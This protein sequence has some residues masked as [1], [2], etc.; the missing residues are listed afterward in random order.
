[1]ERYNAK[2]VEEKW[3]KFWEKEKIY[4]FDPK[5]KKKIYSIDTPPPTISG[6][7]HLGTAFSY[8]QQDFIVRFRRMNGFNIFYPFGTDDNG[9]ATIRLIEKEKKVKAFDLGREKFIKLV[10]ETLKKELRPK[11]IADWK[12]LGMS[13]EWNIYYTTIDD[14]CRKISQKS[15]IE[16]YKKG[17][18]Y[19]KRTP[20]M[21]C[22]EC[23]TSIAQVEMKD[24]ETKS[25][26]VYIKLNT[27]L[28][29]PITIATT[30]P[31]LMPACVAVHVNPKDKRYKKF[32][33]KKAKLPLFDRE[34]NIYA[35][36]DVDMDFGSGAVYHC[37][38]GDMD[39]VEW[40]K[41]MNLD[42]IEI[43]NKDGTF[44]EKAGK[45]K[46]MKS[47]QVREKIIGDLKKLKVIEKIEPIEHVINVHE[48]CDTPI[49]IL[50]TEQW[51][52]KY[53]DLKKQMLNWGKKLNWYPKYMKVRYDNWVKGLKWDWNISRQKFYGIP[54]PVWYCKKCNEIILADE[55]QLPVDPL[56]D[57][58]KKKCKCG[59]DE[60]EG[61]KDVLDTWA[62]SSLTPQIAI[63]LMPKEIQ[64]KLFPMSLRPQAHDIISFWLFKT[65]VKN[66]LHYHKNPFKDVM[67][68]GFVLDPEGKKMSKSKGNVIAP[69]DIIDTYGADALRFWAAGSKLG[70]DLS[71]QEKDL[72][73]GKK[74]ITKLLNASRFVF[75]NLK[76]YKGQKPKKFE[77]LDRL[78]L[79]MLD[80]H[81]MLI[82]KNFKEYNYSM[83]KSRIEKLFWSH[84]CD[85][86][87][88]IIK[89]RIY[90]GK[91]DK[92]ISAQ[93]TLYHSL[94]IILKLVAPIMPF[95]AEEIYQNYFKE[96]E[97][98]KSIHISKW[99]EYKKAPKVNDF[100]FLC[101]LL[102]MV[103]KEKTKKQKSMNAECII[104]LTKKDSKEV[105]KFLEDFKSASGAYVVEVGKDF[106]VEFPKAGTKHKP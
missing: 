94:L 37:T 81:V 103:R 80:Y 74:F 75:M 8:S 102:S 59:N 62:T 9:L 96:Y 99:P 95:I 53:L 106:K 67:I 76:D 35:N 36:E 5:S 56:K 87:L 104:C 54:I 30:R 50:M 40:I 42:P 84:F 4:K 18:E 24:K 16:L 47:E 101:N 65:V 52:I 73:T 92:K 12:R 28:G 31:E 48:R 66:Q 91:G 21:W 60:F 58:P 17:R 97:K 41:K 20:F 29:E 10:L 23:Q 71:Y 3:R 55:K 83:A 86:Y 34:V 72:I 7:M 64:K 27:S 22:P 69:Q 43:M 100:L 90:N 2:K 49:E 79:K 70:E 77:E 44:N 13:C 15:F 57:K 32:I 63:Q 6:K 61:E 82:T 85:N 39:D 1:M 25:N 105:E 78:F 11:Y 98:E 88:E 51:F 93:F 26:F 14:H 45:Y 68:S 89:K 46:G 33:G 38:F 19:R